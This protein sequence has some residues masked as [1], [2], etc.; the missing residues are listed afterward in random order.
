MRQ[1]RPAADPP[2]AAAWPARLPLPAPPAPSSALRPWG[3][4]GRPAQLQQ[5][6]EG[7]PTSKGCAA[8]RERVR[9]QCCGCLPTSGLVLTT[10]LALCST[11]RSHHLQAG[12]LAFLQ[13]PPVAPLR[14]SSAAVSRPIPLVGPVTMT[15]SPSAGPPIRSRLGR[16]RIHSFCKQGLPGVAQQAERGDG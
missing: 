3:C 7:G 6:A 11:E 12:Q 8:A 5:G 9:P 2:P 1:N 13:H 4:C 14:A 10:Q 16:P 15:V